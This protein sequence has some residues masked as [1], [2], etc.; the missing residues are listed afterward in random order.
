MTT[1]GDIVRRE[2]YELREQ[3]IEFQANI[4]KKYINLELR[5]KQNEG[6]LSDVPSADTSCQILGA[7]VAACKDCGV[8]RK[9][10]EEMKEENESMK[11]RVSELE[12]KVGFPD[13][14]YVL[15]MI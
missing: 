11:Q 3:M 14:F 1:T 13:A 12:E 6:K 10:Y 4:L 2:T 15:F 8:F 5:I 9:Q 7:N